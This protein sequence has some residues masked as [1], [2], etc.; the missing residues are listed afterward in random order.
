MR[1]FYILLVLS[2]VMSSFQDKTCRSQIDDLYGEW[3]F[4]GMYQGR[5][6]KIDKLKTNN[7]TSRSGPKSCTYEMSGVYIHRNGE[8]T[9]NGKYTFDGKTCTIVKVY[10]NGYKEELNITYLDKKFLLVVVE[11]DIS[12]FTYFYKRVHR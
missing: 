4:Q 2:F 10:D 9:T 12:A 11:T 6:R 7:N 3:D 5:I 8:T 1:Q